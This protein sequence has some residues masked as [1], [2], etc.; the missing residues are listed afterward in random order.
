MDAFFASVEQRDHPQYRGKPLAVGGSRERGVVAA[1]SYEARKFGVRSAMPSKLAYIK[2]PD[3]IFVKHRFDVYKEVSAQI[4][5]IFLSYTDLVEPL[6]LDEAYLDVTHHKKGPPSATLI[7]KE[8]K[9]EIYKKTQLTASA[10]ISTNKFLAKVASDYDKPNGIYVITPDQ[11]LPFISELPI[12]KFFGV[13]KVTAAKMKKLGIHT[14]ADLKRY[15][16]KDLMRQF[17]KAGVYYFNI[18]R[19]IDERP[20][21]SNRKRKSVGAERTFDTDLHGPDQIKNTLES[22]VKMVEERVKKGNHRGRT[23]TLKIKYSDFQTITRS[24][25]LSFATQDYQMIFDKSIELLSLVDLEGKGVR[26]VGVSVSNLEGEESKSGAQ[27][28]LSF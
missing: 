21:V 19:G 6:S 10:G 12:E 3:I 15:S 18:S 13:G 7:A 25:S 4:R 2:C 24:L 14:G 20:V 28:T 1:A 5:E 26:L 22:I 11:V 9:A 17:G 23:I 27:L 16:R 8:I